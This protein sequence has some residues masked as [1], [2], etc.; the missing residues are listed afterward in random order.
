MSLRLV[1]SDLTLMIQAQ[2]MH[3]LNPTESNL[4]ENINMSDIGG[5]KWALLA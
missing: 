1:V 3:T 4:S 2:M 5:M